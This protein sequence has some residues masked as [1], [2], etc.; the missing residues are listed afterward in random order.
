MSINRYLLNNYDLRISAFGSPKIWNKPSI[1]S[2]KYC[3]ILNS[4]TDVRRDTCKKKHDYQSKI[5]DYYTYPRD[6]KLSSKS[7]SN[8]DSFA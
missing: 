1:I 8:I 6:N 2:G 7:I 5:D 4:G 3:T